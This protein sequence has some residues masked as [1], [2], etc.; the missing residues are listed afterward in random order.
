MNGTAKKVA[1]I[2]AGVSG[3]VCARLLVGRGLDV[4][5]FDKGRGV[6]GRCS[7]RR[8]EMPGKPPILMSHGVARFEKLPQPLHDE[9]LSIKLIESDSD[10]ADSWRVRDGSSA[11]CKHLA[12]GLNVRLLKQISLINHDGRVW[13]VEDV[14][15]THEVEFDAVV[16]AIPVDQARIMLGAGAM[17]SELES[18]RVRPVWAGLFGF[19]SAIGEGRSMPSGVIEQFNIMPDAQGDSRGVVVHMNE[20]WTREHLEQRADDVMP[21]IQSA[22]MFEREPTFAAA[23][24]WR[25][26]RTTTPLGRASLADMARQLVVCGDWCLGDGVK[27][28]VLSGMAAAERISAD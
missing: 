13:R 10:V 20:A 23:H 27:D 19:D 24:R 25:Y 9:L 28:A 6:G 7:T 12:A 22:A 15:A 1:V 2:G 11:L 14:D 18:V 26:A 5:V 8:V 16:L 3:L 21:L 4:V 17:Q